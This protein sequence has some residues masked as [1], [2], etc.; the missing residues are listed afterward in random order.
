MNSMPNEIDIPAVDRGI[1]KPIRMKKKFLAEVNHA[2]K[3][4]V[5]F[6]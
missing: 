4:A 1:E 6:V 3:R 5:R 2:S